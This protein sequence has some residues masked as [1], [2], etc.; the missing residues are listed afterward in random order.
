M[1]L[2]FVPSYQ[3]EVEKEFADVPPPPLHDVDAVDAVN[4][5]DAVDAVDASD[6]VDAAPLQ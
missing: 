4:A 3:P 5:V 2:L 6:A 1:A